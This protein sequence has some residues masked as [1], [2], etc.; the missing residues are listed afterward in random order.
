VNLA[1][2][3]LMAKLEAP[4]EEAAPARRNQLAATLRATELE[5]AKLAAA[6]ATGDAPE[7]LLAAIRD[8]E[9]TGLPETSRPQ[10]VKA[11][12]GHDFSTLLAN[13]GQASVTAV[14]PAVLFDYVGPSTV[15]GSYLGTLVSNRLFLHKPIPPLSRAKLDQRGFLWFV[16]DGR[17]KFARFYAPTSFSTPRT[18]DDLFANN[19]VQLFDLQSDPEEVHNLALDRERNRETLLRMNGLLN[20]LI[21]K[22]VGANDG[23]FLKDVV[24]RK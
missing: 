13:P 5:L 8:R 11:L 18:L 17:Y 4:Q 19:D 22:E 9:R 6:I 20:D 1:L 23:R 21:A 10:V 24:G 12:P 7:T 2:D 3:K 14:R 15:D 16:F